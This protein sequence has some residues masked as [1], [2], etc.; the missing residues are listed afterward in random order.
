MKFTFASNLKQLRLKRGLTQE[1]AA[2]VLGTSPQ[3]V[4][5]W[6]CGNTMPDVLMLP[7]IAELYCVTID[8]LFHGNTIAYGSYAERLMSIYE[9]TREPEDFVRADQEMKKLIK[10]GEATTD[11]LRVYGCIHQMMMTYCRDQALRLFDI[12]LEKEKQDKN[13]IYLS[14]KQ[15]KLSLLAQLGRI[16]EGIEEQ[17]SLIESGCEQVQE[18]I[19]LIAAYEFAGELEKAYEYF[20]KAERKFTESPVLYGLGG[21]ICRKMKKY[22]EAFAYWDKAIAIRP[23]FYSAKYSKGFCYEELGEY[24][25]AC[26]VWYE[27]IDN[28]REEGLD[29]E[30]EFPEKL[31]ANCEAK[32]K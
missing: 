16:Q 25:K 11:A 17:L 31:A 6:E 18:W 2:E 12:V 19:C 32:I 23:L 29:L 14:A 4:S 3:S 30:I 27:I 7:A 22:D 13:D 20:V 8:D 10:S 5:R 26:K 24:D 21:D 15:Q 28:L 9:T 1:Q